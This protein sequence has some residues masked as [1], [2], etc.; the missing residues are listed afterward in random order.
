VIAAA[1]AIAAGAVAGALAIKPAVARDGS[2]LA[3]SVGPFTLVT[4]SN[5]G[6]PCQQYKN[7]LAGSGVEGDAASGT[8][9]KGTSSGI[10]TIGVGGTS[11]KGT[12]VK[13]VSTSANGAWGISS[14]SNG[15]E[16]DSTSGVGVYG[17]S[18]TDVGVSGLCNSCTAVSGATQTGNG[19]YGSASSSGI[20]VYGSSNGGIGSYAYSNST[21]GA[22]A[23][24]NTGNA[25]FV[26]SASGSY[27]IY[28]DAGSGAPVAAF[29][30]GANASY[31][32]HPNGGGASAYFDAT[33]GSNFG[34]ISYSNGSS[35]SAAVFGDD[36]NSNGIG[37]DF[38]GYL[39]VVGVSNTVPII[40]ENDVAQS[41]AYIDSSGNVFA[42]GSY[43]HY[44]RTRDGE[45]AMGF[46][47]ESTAPTI[48]DD[49]TAQL[50]NGEAYVSLDPA[51]AKAIDVSHAYHV[52]LT[53]DGDTRGLFVAN[54]SVTGF[55]VREVQGG[56]SSISFD[57]HIYA[58][59]FGR[60]DQHMTTFFGR[61]P[62]E[63]KLPV[64]RPRPEYPVLDS[65]PRIPLPHP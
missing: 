13:G 9:V 19:V 46:G 22:E 40:A 65:P 44:S 60:A 57:Y 23:L 38:I 62:G 45:T 56:R 54:K 24:S 28:A 31:Y 64:L 6:G 42:H 35:G 52:M 1:I 36:L 4:C 18:S 8:G 7:L 53:P 51:F 20:G 27:S 61:P 41:V 47:S 48:E 33:S 15:V 17:T 21:Y 10:G 39:G 29:G 49:G 5:K 58:R 14:S 11:S 55:E 37:G 43:N 32:A 50:I 25:L 16:G 12:G 63:P 30:S 3:Y 59:E 34:V 2:V 26:D